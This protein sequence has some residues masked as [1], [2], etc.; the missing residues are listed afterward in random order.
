MKILLLLSLLLL[1]TPKPSSCLQLDII[2]IGDFSGSVEHHEK[3]VVDAFTAFSSKFVLSDETVQ[4]GILTFSS[5][6]TIVCPLTADNDLFQAS[7]SK[8]STV[9]AGGGTNLTEALET[10][11]DEFQTHGRRGYR[12]II[13]LVCDGVVDSPE[14]ALL[15][16]QQMKTLAQVGVFGVLIKDTSANPAFMK[17][18]SSDDCYVES[19]YETLATELKKLDI[20]L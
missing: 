15:T 11:L 4:M 5:T 20:C 8:M 2:L 14:A 18:I 1:S 12:K 6:T 13:I 17:E 3:F 7:L 10:A 16:S 19:D 9:K